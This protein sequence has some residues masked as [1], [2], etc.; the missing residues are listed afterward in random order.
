MAD[1]NPQPVNETW[2]RIKE[3]AIVFGL[4]IG[5]V[6]ALPVLLPAMMVSQRRHERRL[7]DDAER[8]DCTECGSRLGNASITAADQAWKA[9][10]QKLQRE[11]PGHRFRLVRSYHAICASCGAK[12]R[13]DDKSRVFVLQ[14]S[15]SQE[16]G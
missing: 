16:A 7:R 10:V 14:E 6:V 12:Y 3:A 11:N 1:L 5:S 15:P 4:V 2:F 13:Y 9:F 8:F